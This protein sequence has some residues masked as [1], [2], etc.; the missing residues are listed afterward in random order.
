MLEQLQ[1]TY[2][3]DMHFVYRHFPLSGIHDKAVLA[4]IASEAAGKQDAFWQFHDLLFERQRDWSN[5]AP[6]QA[7]ELFA[8]YAFELGLDRDQFLADMDDPA[9]KQ[10]V[11]D[12]ETAAQDAGLRGTP[13]VFINGYEFPS[14]DLPLNKE[15]VDFFLQIIRTLEM[16]YNQPEQVLE[17]GKQYQATIETEK[18]DIVIDLFSDT[19]PLNTNSFAF[20]AEKGWYDNTTFHRVLA[21]FMAQGGDPLG[22]GIG[23]PG[24][25]CTDEV[26]DTRKFDKAGVVAMA[27]SGPNTNGA[28]FFIT[29]GPAEHLNDDFT[30]IGQVVS[31]QD[32]VDSLTLRDPEAQPAFEGDKILKVT[33]SEKK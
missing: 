17:A 7:K 30:I 24:Y 3:D 27:N 21:D 23:W 19:A 28:Q 18:G 2:G 1:E 15:G 5:F 26:V 8:N 32:V 10:I 31:G 12:A 4:S 14:Q 6:E 25:R 33:I 20:L 13:T 29:F 22:L 11:A 9:L 16:Q